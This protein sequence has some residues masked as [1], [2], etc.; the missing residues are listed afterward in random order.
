MNLDFSIGGEVH[1]LMQDY[2]NNSITDVGA[3][4]KNATPASPYLFD[5]NPD[6]L[7][8]PEH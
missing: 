4:Q 2:I 1:I 7:L 8:L 5:V 6:C 3:F